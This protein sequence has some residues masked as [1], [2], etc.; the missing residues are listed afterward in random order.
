MS[1]PDKKE[2]FMKKAERLACWAARDEY[3]SCLDKSNA[4][5]EEC[6]QF[7]ERYITECPASWVVHFDR[8]YKYLKFKEQAMSQGYES[9][10]EAYEKN[11]KS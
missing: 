7:R 2:K 6:Q 5:G 1:D 11:K 4:V 9:M 10:D 8:K 3:W